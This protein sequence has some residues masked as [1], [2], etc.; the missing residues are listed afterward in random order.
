MKDE[1]LQAV[2]E[3]ARHFAACPCQCA[4][5]ELDARR[6]PEEG[7]TTASL[8]AIPC[9]Q[10]RMRSALEAYDDNSYPFV[11]VWGMTNQQ[12]LKAE[13][14]TIPQQKYADILI[15]S[16]KS[17]QCPHCNVFTNYVECAG[18][19]LDTFTLDHQRRFVKCKKCGVMLVSEP[20]LSNIR[21]NRACSGCIYPEES[22]DFGPNCFQSELQDDKRREVESLRAALAKSLAREAAAKAK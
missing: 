19:D 1:L 22:H 5:L 6:R 14:L 8:Y 21:L 16:I 7:P 15:Q 11:R 3:A 20:N 4:A 13:N 2:I 17:F 10:C 18:I 12:L 9:N